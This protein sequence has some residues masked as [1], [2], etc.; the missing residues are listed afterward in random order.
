MFPFRPEGEGGTEPDIIGTADE[1][2]GR[3]HLRWPIVT[4]GVFA[5]GG[6]ITV[7]VVSHPH[8]PAAAPHPSA[9][10]SS[11][12]R[13]APSAPGPVPTQAWAASLNIANWPMPGSVTGTSG[14]MI[15]GG[16]AGR[17]A[18]GNSGWELT[19]RDAAR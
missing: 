6:V 14:G 16:V 11:P 12:A 19:V 4:A 5:L 7:A 2:R 8:R 13:P 1:G 10:A 17:G 3:R 18:G 15:A 9:V